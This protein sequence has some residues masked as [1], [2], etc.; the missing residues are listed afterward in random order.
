MSDTNP[1]ILILTPVK[2]AAPSLETYFACLDQL[3]YPSEHL[4]LGFLESDSRDGT[5]EKLTDILA[6]RGD[7]YRRTGLWKRDYGFTL[8]D[9][10]PRWAPAMQL[11]RRIILAKSRNQLL[12]RALRDESWVLWIDVDVI[13]YPK[14]VLHR[15]LA[16]DRRIVHPHCVL[17]YGGPTFDLNAWRDRGDVHMDQLRGGEDL[18]RLD[19]VGG[20]M[21]LID[22]DLH[23]DGLIFPAF[24]YGGEVSGIRDIV[25]WLP[26]GLRGEVE[27]EGLGIMAKSMGVQCWGMPNLE[28]L[29]AKA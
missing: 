10:M 23:R 15:L 7:K 13:E 14:D 18:V 6:E 12:F 26:K 9:G 24:P 28:I 22:A 25:D 16:V 27:T 4:S 21:L 8:R 17:D 19:S 3:D 2:D 5:F 1:N 20:T 11:P 29:H